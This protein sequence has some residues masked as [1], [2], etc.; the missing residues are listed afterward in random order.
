MSATTA[1]F[2]Q[3]GR[4]RLVTV[5]PPTTVNRACYWWRNLPELR[6][7]GPAT[8]ASA[9]G[10]GRVKTKTDLVIMPSGGRIFAFIFS[11]RDHRPQ[12]S[13]CSHTAQSFHTAW[14]KT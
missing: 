13:G 5:A 2:L 1:A 14:A 10:L 4:R 11:A 7:L 6:T 9:T 3:S 8:P 12:N